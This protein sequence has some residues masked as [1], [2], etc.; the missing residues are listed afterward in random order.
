[1]VNFQHYLYRV[2]FIKNYQELL[3]NC[4][5][6]LRGCRLDHFNWFYIEKL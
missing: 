4:K 3:S 5:H 2:E 6:E 1:M